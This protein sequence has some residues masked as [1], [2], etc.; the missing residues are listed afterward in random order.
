MTPFVKTR[1]ARSWAAVAALAI[2]S[3]TGIET[4]ALTQ[5]IDGNALT[6]ALAAITALGGASVGRVL[7]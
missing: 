5:G 4:Y 3:I 2:L 6:A 7:K 1:L